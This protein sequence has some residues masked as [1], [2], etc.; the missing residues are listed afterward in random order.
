MDDVE[1]CTDPRSNCWQGDARRLKD[2]V[3]ALWTR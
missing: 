3:C 1:T 2:G